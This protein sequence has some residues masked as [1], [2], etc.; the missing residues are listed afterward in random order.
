MAPCFKVWV[1][2]QGEIEADAVRIFA[3]D[4]EGAALRRVTGD[5]RE[6]SGTIVHLRSTSVVGPEELGPLIKI[7]VTYGMEVLGRKDLPTDAPRPYEDWQEDMGPCLWWKFPIG[8]PPYVG[9]P[10]DDDFPDD[11]VT[12]FTRIP[13]P[14]KPWPTTST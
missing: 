6:T 1:P 3:L 7:R 11:F 2:S 4:E 13:V 9:T 12:H 5:R 14:E 8:E 10:G